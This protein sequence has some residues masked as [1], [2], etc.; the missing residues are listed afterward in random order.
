MRA[1]VFATLLALTLL[2]GTGDAQTVTRRLEWDQPNATVV[3]ASGYVY[4]AQID[5]LS[6]QALVQTCTL[7]GLTTHCSAPFLLPPNLPVGS[8]TVALTVSNAFGSATA[9][10]TGSTPLPPAGITIKVIVT[11][12]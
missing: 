9:G 7:V 2:Q 8:H 1:Y 12:P 6:P 4:S 11:V 5:A 10:I 3:E